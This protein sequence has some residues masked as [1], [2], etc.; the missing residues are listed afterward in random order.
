V[1]YEARETRPED[2]HFF[3]VEVT[4]AACV[5]TPD[6]RILGSNVVDVTVGFMLAPGGRR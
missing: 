3:H 2:D 6:S 5:G 4:I 1:S